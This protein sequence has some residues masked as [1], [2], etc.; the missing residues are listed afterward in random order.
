M[1]W[2][3]DNRFKEILCNIQKHQLTITTSV[4][5]IILYK[6]ITAYQE[7]LGK[8]YTFHTRLE[9]FCSESDYYTI[10]FLSSMNFQ[11]QQ[12]SL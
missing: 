6:L 7:R 4:G 12:L 3:L 1:N 8:N 5:T 11:S 10:S 2:N 9:Q